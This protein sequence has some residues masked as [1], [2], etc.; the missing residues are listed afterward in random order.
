MIKQI[1]NTSF[2]LTI[3][4][5]YNFQNNIDVEKYYSIIII[6]LLLTNI[7]VLSQT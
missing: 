3:A 2:Y 7:I 4:T 5:K 6:A 1:A